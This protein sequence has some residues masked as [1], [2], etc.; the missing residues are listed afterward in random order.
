[1]KGTRGAGP[2]LQSVPVYEDINWG[3]KTH[4]GILLRK[5]A[6]SFKYKMA[7]AIM[8]GYKNTSIYTP[9]LNQYIKLQKLKGIG[10]LSSTGFSLKGAGGKK[11]KTEAV[12]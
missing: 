6:S 2:Y 7:R 4:R 3:V 11:I 8:F 5:V 10:H 9:V 1:M 12:G